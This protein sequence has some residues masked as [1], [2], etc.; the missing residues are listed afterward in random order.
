M[1][2]AHDRIRLL[3]VFDSTRWRKWDEDITWSDWARR[4]IPHD[5]AERMLSD[6]ELE[7]YIHQE[8]PDETT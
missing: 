5:H 8:I 2:D 3:V 7:G 1:Q 6:V 4:T